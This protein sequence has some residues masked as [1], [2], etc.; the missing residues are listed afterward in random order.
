MKNPLNKKTAQSKQPKQPKQKKPNLFTQLIA[1]KSNQPKANAQKSTTKKTGNGLLDKLRGKKSPTKPSEQMTQTQAPSQPNSENQHQANVKKGFVLPSFGKKQPKTK[2]GHH[3]EIPTT[4]NTQKVTT[5]YNKN[6]LQQLLATKGQFIIF[7]IIVL[8]VLLSAFVIAS[9]FIWNND[10]QTQPAP[11]PSIATNIATNEQQP[12]EVDEEVSAVSD[13]N[14][15]Q[16]TDNTDN[17]EVEADLQPDTATAQIETDAEIDA[18]A[19]AR[20]EE[21]QSQIANALKGVTPGDAKKRGGNISYDEFVR[22]SK[23]KIYVE[24]KSK[25]REQSE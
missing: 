13:E 19:D 6:T 3:S 8:I 17:A 20:S 7:A 24:E 2:K 16:D 18:K 1:K 14:T 25:K 12:D 11:M 23:N 21:T 9:K 5:K 15:T 10:E 4:Q 22:E